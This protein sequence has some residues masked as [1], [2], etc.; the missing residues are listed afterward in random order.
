[1]SHRFFQAKQR[2]RKAKEKQ[3]IKSIEKCKDKR[4]RNQDAAK[5]PNLA[6]SKHMT[7]SFPDASWM[8]IA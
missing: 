8:A 3:K 1:M 7:P 2:L 4:Q 6:I 5:K